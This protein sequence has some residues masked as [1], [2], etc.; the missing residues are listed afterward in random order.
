MNMVVT[1]EENVRSLVKSIITRLENQKAISMRPVDRE[2]LRQEVYQ[3]V[4]LSV[5]TDQDLHEKTLAALGA[6]AEE[7]SNSEF[8]ESSQYRAAKA[9]VRKSFGDDT[10][11]GFYFTENIKQ[12]AIHIR[13]FLMNSDLIEDVYETD[14][15][16]EQMIVE[17]IKKFNPA[18]AH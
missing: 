18:A 7:L 3:L 15:D 2:K 16:L 5:K 14:H 8:T 13:E 10:L 17:I 9:I 6:K 4:Q 11:N 1:N 12:I